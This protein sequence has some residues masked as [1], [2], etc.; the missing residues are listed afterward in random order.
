MNAPPRAWTFGIVVAC[1][2]VNGGIGKDGRLPWHLPADMKHFKQLTLKPG[3]VNIVIMGKRTWESL[4][5]QRALPGRINIVLS[6]S[7]I[8][9]LLSARGAIVLRSF[10]EALDYCDSVQAPGSP[11]N[12]NVI[13]GAGVYEQAMLHP[14]CVVAHVTHIKC[15]EASQQQYDAWFPLELLERSYA[16]ARTDHP[17]AIDLASG[18]VYQFIDY[19]RIA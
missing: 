12:V 2:A 10:E 15:Q 5:E 13:G 11:L 1:D 14:Q 7:A 19:K 3:H 18:C 9:K 6:S 4:P 17:P 16:A 8:P